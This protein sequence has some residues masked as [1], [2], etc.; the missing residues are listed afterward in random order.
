M[1]DAGTG[2]ADA[3]RGVDPVRIVLL[4]LFVAAATAT[5][6][7]TSP[8]F[9]EPSDVYRGYRYLRIFDPAVGVEG[10]PPGIAALT[11][12]P[13]LAALP[14]ADTPLDPDARM[15]PGR[16]QFL[17]QND[18]RGLRFFPLARGVV[19]LLAA[20]L[21]WLVYGEAAGRYGRA[22]GRLALALYVL[23][24]NFLANGS[25][26]T[27]DV[28]AALAT[29]LVIV[30]LL[31]WSRRRTVARAVA[32]GAALGFA[33]LAKFSVLVL[34]ALLPALAAILLVRRPG[35][36]PLPAVLRD[37]ALAAVIA[38]TMVWAAHGFRVGTIDG[39]RERIRDQR[40][41]IAREEVEIPPAWYDRVPLPAPA[42]L[43]GITRQF[44]HAYELGHEAYFR[45]EHS[46]GGW[47]SYY[48][49]ILFAKTPLPTLLLWLLALA[50]FAR[51]HPDREE[52]VLLLFAAVHFAAAISSSAVLGY[53]ILLPMLPGLFVLAGR[54]AP[55]AVAPPF[56]AWGRVR[57]PALAVALLWL[58]AGTAR[59]L[60]H[61]LAYFNEAVG[62]PGGAYRYVAGADL[63]WGQD[64]PGLARW[65]REH[66][67]G[68]IFLSYFGTVDPSQYGID[69]RP[70][71]LG[72]AGPDGT[73]RADRIPP[74]V[75]AISVSRLV[76]LQSLGETPLTAFL[77]REP[78]A[79]IGHSIHVYVVE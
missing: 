61:P 35:A 52:C 17:E 10:H 59:S 70:I 7:R 65:V 3:R 18:G 34:V 21:G 26:A 48:P 51:R 5:A 25:L 76:G 42:Y 32:M 74:G 77:E 36:P 73:F 62:G 8:T 55:P 69:W 2:R 13:M 75:Y 54:L 15:S 68:R 11:A 79:I 56:P 44:R 57:V 29:W 66:D 16:K 19:I 6:L 23:D 47:A 27:T 20:L 1:T 30:A 28:G 64:L 43:D 12:L 63:D 24:P 9:D 38:G 22:G 40:T 60:P 49:W 71:L 45:G 14:P 39:V 31:R 72:R 50:S 58:C 67:A 4:V 53:R 78:A 46:E 41:R 33:L 37:I